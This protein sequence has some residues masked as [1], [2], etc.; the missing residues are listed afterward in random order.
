[1]GQIYVLV[2]RVTD[3][4]NFLL[5]GLPPKDLWEDVSEA[6]RRAGLNVDDC[7]KRALSV[8][9][10]WLCE[11]GVGPLKTLVRQRICHERSV[12]LKNRTLAEVLDPQPESCFFSSVLY[13]QLFPPPR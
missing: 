2:S 13:D 1:M 9:N 5:T 3:P 11:P 12:P 8:C 4:Q 10:E 6:W 7:W